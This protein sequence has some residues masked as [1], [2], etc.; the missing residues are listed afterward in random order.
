[1]AS[2]AG[3]QSWLVAPAGRVL[4]VSLFEAACRALAVEDPW[5][6]DDELVPVDLFDH[7]VGPGG[8]APAD[9]LRLRSDCPVAPELLKL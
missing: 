3:R 9:R 6:A 8:L 4:P 1:V 2:T 5:D 7:M